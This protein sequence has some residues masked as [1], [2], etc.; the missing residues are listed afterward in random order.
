MLRRRLTVTVRVSELHQTQ[1]TKQLVLEIDFELLVL[2]YML[3]VFALVN[4]ILFLTTLFYRCFCL[5]L[6]STFESA[7]TYGIK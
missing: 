3:I 4:I 5:C 1:T 2:N 7:S 6:P